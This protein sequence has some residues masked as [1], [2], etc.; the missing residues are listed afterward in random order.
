VAFISSFSK[1]QIP[2]FEF[3]SIYDF[4]K[5]N[6]KWNFKNEFDVETLSKSIQFTRKSANGEKQCFSNPNEPI[7][8]K[9]L[10]EIDELA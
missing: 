9:F 3:L 8:Y 6:L 4:W 1:I 10:K 2:E 7:H 5:Q